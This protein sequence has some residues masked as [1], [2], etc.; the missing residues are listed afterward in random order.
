MCEKLSKFVYRLIYPMRF[1][2]GR[3]AFET[4][5]ER[6]GIRLSIPRQSL[7]IGRKIIKVSPE[8]LEKM[9][10]TTAVSAT[11]GSNVPVTL[12]LPETVTCVRSLRVPGRND[13]F[14]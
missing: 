13:T 2:G 8:T 14:V 9:P 3:L 5:R 1:P 11:I 4:S 10:G 7:K 12:T 6:I